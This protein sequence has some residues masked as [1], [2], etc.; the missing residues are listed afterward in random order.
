[1]VNL[2]YNYSSNLESSLRNI[3]NLRQKILLYPLSPRIELRL[4]W[5]AMIE[6]VYWS[7][8]MAGNNLS[9]SQTVKILSQEKAIKRMNNSEKEVMNYKKAL[10]HLK[11]EWL[12]SP[13]IITVNTILELYNIS[14]KPTGGSIGHTFKTR[15][16]EIQHFLD[17]LQTGKEH[18]VIQAGVAQIQ[19]ISLAPFNVG[20]GRTARLIPYLILYKYGYNFRDLLVI[21][22]YFTK[23]LLSLKHAIETAEKNKNLT[24]WLEFFTKGVEIQLREAFKIMQLN[25]FSTDVPAS[26]W[27]LNDRQKQ[28]LNLLDQPGAKISNKKVQEIFKVSQITASRD[29]SSLTNLGLLFAHGKGRSVYYTKV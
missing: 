1:M 2:L 21:D 22:K 9:K 6:K 19:M 27:K 17:Y 13:K 16:R 25:R 15:E 18:P 8:N 23:D 11:Q 4:K 26:F 29:L 7:L 20:N 14:V 12:I 24:I 10:D 3:E 5:E 28:I